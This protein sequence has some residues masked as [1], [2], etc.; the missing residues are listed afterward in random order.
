M[1][2]FSELSK[3]QKF[4]DEEIC[5]WF[6]ANVTKRDIKADMEKLWWKALARG[7]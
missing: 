4:I 6:I 5:Y 1:K 3:Y 7:G 2:K